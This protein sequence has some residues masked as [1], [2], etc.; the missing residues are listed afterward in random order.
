MKES[1]PSP[2][3]SPMPPKS[4]Q[5]SEHALLRLMIA[6]HTALMNETLHLIREVRDLVSHISALID[7]EHGSA[8]Q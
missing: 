5:P 7:A 6:E 1:G 8:A 4:A 2:G 3:K